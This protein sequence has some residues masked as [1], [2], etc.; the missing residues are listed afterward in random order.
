ML[1]LF[2][3]VVNNL[4]ITL[5]PFALRSFRL[6]GRRL[7]LFDRRL[8]DRRPNWRRIF[9]GRRRFAPVGSCITGVSGCR[10]RIGNGRR[11]LGPR[12]LL[13][14]GHSRRSAFSD[15]PS[16]RVYFAR[17]DPLSPTVSAAG[18]GKLLVGLP[19]MNRFMKALK[20]GRAPWPPV[21]PSPRFS[22]RCGFPI[23]T[24][25]T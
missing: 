19:F 20:Y 9:T 21:I 18:F 10:S 23:Q 15:F 17:S 3:L 25:V 16:S 4:P 14:S 6:F 1:P 2:C 12:S 11:R 22:F 5:L 8:L 24:P 13:R 7:R